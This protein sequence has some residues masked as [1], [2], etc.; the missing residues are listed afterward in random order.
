MKEK[1]MTDNHH[2]ET[3]DLT[4]LDLARAVK[5]LDPEI[6]PERDLWVGIERQI[7]DYPQNPRK[8]WS[9]DWMPYGVAASL[10]V[11][12]SALILN[13]VQLNSEES[14]LV[15]AEQTFNQMQVDYVQLRNPLV[16]KFGEVNKN[17]DEKTLDDLYR[18]LDILENARKEIETQVRENPENRKL[19]E[20][21]MRI[22][23]QEL[24]LLR[25]DFSH[26]GNFL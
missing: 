21:L 7:Q 10:I 5:D 26:S 13:M 9:N 4:D 20:M 16:Q 25:K 23:E 11:A 15:S 3:S 24:D 18:N 8:S 6:K 17:L 19:V 12:F 22:H 2:N 14:G 1:I